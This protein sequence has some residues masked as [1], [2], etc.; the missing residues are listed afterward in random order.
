MG[1]PRRF[2]PSLLQMTTLDPWS[3]ATVYVLYACPQ[4]IRDRVAGPGRTKYF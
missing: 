4:G 3:L 1:S 2:L